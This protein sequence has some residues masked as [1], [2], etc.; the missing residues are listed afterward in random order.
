MSMGA[1]V[2]NFMEDSAVAVQKQQQAGGVPMSD[3]V[4]VACF[5]VLCPKHEKCQKYENV[6]TT[7]TRLWQTTCDTA[8]NGTFGGFVPLPDAN[9]EA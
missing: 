6:E 9:N 3:E 4:A 1:I 8:H 2:L 5:G 7:T